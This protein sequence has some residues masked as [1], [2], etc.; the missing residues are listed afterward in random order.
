MELNKNELH[1][2]KWLSFYRKLSIGCI[3]F[4]GIGIPYG[5]YYYFF[6]TKSYAEGYLNNALIA[7]SIVVLGMGYLMYSF[8]KIIEKLKRGR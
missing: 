5:L 7:A 3:V 6:H 2:L 8:V 1:I 4:G